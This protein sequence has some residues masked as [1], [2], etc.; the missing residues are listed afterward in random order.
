M[1]ALSRALALAV[2]GAALWA[3]AANATSLPIHEGWSLSRARAAL[4]KSGWKP[5][6]STETFA[7][8]TRIDQSGQPGGFYKAGY[9]EVED[10][11]EGPAYCLFRYRKHGKCLN[12]TTQG[13]YKNPP[14]V[15]WDLLCRK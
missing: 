6:V 11:S 15:G 8:G 1:T 5:V 10:C 12:V 3:V 9:I 13:E 7:D 14:I 4:V 2:A